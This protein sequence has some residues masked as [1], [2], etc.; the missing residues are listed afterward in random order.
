MFTCANDLAPPTHM[1]EEAFLPLLPPEAT[2]PHHPISQNAASSCVHHQCT[3]FYWLTWCALRFIAGCTMRVRWHGKAHAAHQGYLLACAHASHVDPFA[4]SALW[5]QPIDWMA[6]V[7]CFRRGWAAWAMRQLRAFSVNRSG[8]PVR[9]IRVARERLQKQ[10]V[11]GVFPEGEVR[12]G[13][14]SVLHGGNIKRGVCLLAL[15]SGRPIVPCLILGTPRLQ[16]VEP[17]L[18]ARR[19]R[20][21]LACGEPIYPPSIKLKGGER[22]IA[23]L[24][25]AAEVEAA[26]RKLYAEAQVRWP[27]TAQI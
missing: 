19:G 17:Y 12:Q 7:E 20:L 8:V 13:Q 9:A 26:L 2:K 22:R 16:R 25:M 21:W 23:R 24:K 10:S 1:S 3:W 27:E 5:P 6:R 15:H 18:P 14:S 4:L 11:V